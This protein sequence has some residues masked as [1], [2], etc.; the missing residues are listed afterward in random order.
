L[1]VSAAAAMIAL[2]ALVMV[3]GFMGVGS[4]LRLIDELVRQQR[5]KLTLICNDTARPGFGVGKLIDAGLVRKVIASHSPAWGRAMDLVTD[6]RRVIA[7][8]THRS[9][10]GSKIVKRC[11]LPTTSVRRVDLIVTEL[12]VIKPNPQGL[13]LIET[14]DGV[15][16]RQVLDATDAELIV[17]PA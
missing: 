16:V 17:E 6:A 7:A 10:L 4:P 15:S 3:G 5:G 11:S 2:G 14:A 9:P 1:S 8:M 12:A 13:L